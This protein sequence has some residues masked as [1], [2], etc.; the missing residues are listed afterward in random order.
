MSSMGLRGKTAKA[1]AR[2]MRGLRPF[3]KG[4]S[5]NPQGGKL[6]KTKRVSAKIKRLTNQDLEKLGSLLTEGD[7]KE[8]KRI[9]KDKSES[10]LRYWTSN[11]IMKAAEKGDS[12]AW[13]QILD[14][15]I[16]KVPQKSSFV[17]D[18]GKDVKPQIVIML[19]KK[20]E[21]EN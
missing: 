16:G 20:N 4:Q 3:K 8:L 1:R 10:P 14:R 18:Q 5:G 6:H 9:A 2:Q 7:F 21:R 11:I 19:P 15:L 17:D 12:F 13:N